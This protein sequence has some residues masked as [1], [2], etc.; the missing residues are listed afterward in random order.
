MSNLRKFIRAIL[1]GM[2]IAVG[3]AVYLCCENKVAGAV[4]FTVGL[5]AV[6]LYSLDLFTGKVAYLFQEGASYILR[7]LIMWIG[8][9]IGAFLTGLALSTVSPTIAENAQKLCEGK[10]EQSWYATIILGFFC[11]ILV[12]IATD[13]YKNK[14][15]TKSQTKYLLLFVCIPAF[16]LA[17]FE[18]SIADMFY[19]AASKDDLLLT[20]KG[21]LFVL[22]VT[23]G[24][25]IGA[26]LFH[27][28][29]SFV[30]HT[31]HTKTQ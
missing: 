7:L 2:M 10:L 17:G 22:L 25:A 9:F 11:G 1:A 8:N 5:V 23:L 3:G 31:H 30:T 16:I 20:L 18:H 6:C 12:Y 28:L 21:Q 14:V 29:K 4:F 19:L 26:I 13:N 27:N 24:N 15:N